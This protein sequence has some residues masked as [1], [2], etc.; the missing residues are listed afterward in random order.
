[1]LLLLA[2]IVPALV[3]SKGT[4][5]AQRACQK[6]DRRQ[7]W[8]AAGTF[9]MG[10]DRA[11]SEERPVRTVSIAGFAIDRFPVTNA[12]FARFVKATAYV[13]DAERKP[14][15][16]AYPDI[17]PDALVAGGA[18]FMAPDGRR[19]PRN[20]AW[21]QFVPG[22][23]WRHPYGPYS[24]I[25]GKDDYPVVQVSYRDAL[26]YARWAGRALPSEEQ[27]EYAARGGLNGR[28][29]A[30]GETLYPKGQ[31][32][33][34]TWQGEFPNEDLG[35][36]GFKGAAPAGCFAPNAFGLYDMIGNVWEWTDSLYDKNDKAIHQS[37]LLRTIKG[38][39][40]LCSPNYCHRYRPS[41]R[42][43]QESGFSTVH[44]GFRTVSLGRAEAPRA[45][46]P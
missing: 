29:Y 32:R 25:A 44:L 36:D 12:Q 38:G 2:V 45:Q 15:A 17:A 1:M 16:V 4:S 21:W 33:A 37:R 24:S 28:T 43:P 39:S 6:P 42:Q 23:D 20:G 10:S 5:P 7:I 3:L 41:A 35:Q 27:Y 8:L 18:V 9:R 13:T 11:Y 22:A 14:D 26:A 34:N 40:F 46:T 30:W 19:D 31:F